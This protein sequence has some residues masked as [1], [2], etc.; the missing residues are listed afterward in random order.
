M[1]PRNPESPPVRGRGLKRPAHHVD[2][3]PLMSPPVRGRGLKPTSWGAEG[4]CIRSPPVRGRGLK[5]GVQRP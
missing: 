4:A 1:A 3:E 2:L 5:L